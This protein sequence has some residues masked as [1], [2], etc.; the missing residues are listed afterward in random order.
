[1]YKGRHKAK[2]EGDHNKLNDLFNAYYNLKENN[3]I[4]AKKAFEKFASTLHSHMLW[5]E[6][7]LFPLLEKKL[8]GYYL[9]VVGTI[10]EEHCQL[11]DYLKIVH[12]KLQKGDKETEKDEHNLMST[13]LKHENKEEKIL[14]PEIIKHFSEDEIKKALNTMNETQSDI[15]IEDKT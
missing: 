8:G 15:F 7:I 11:L 12:E 4:S 14:H 5:E 9:E 6:R 10:K 13:L 1:M 2:F 3:Q